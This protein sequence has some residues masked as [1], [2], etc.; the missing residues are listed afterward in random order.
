M[1]ETLIVYDPLVSFQRIEKEY[2]QFY[3]L[4]K[5]LPSDFIDQ[6]EEEIVMLQSEM[7]P[8]TK[9]LAIQASMVT[10]HS[11]IFPITKIEGSKHEYCINLYLIRDAQPKPVH[12]E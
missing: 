9:M 1:F 12:P 6:T 8:M 4:I 3:T 11:L 2:M 10:V 5:F 7:K